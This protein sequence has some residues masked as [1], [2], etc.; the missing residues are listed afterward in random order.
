MTLAE[1]ITILAVDD[2]PVILNTVLSVLRSEYSVVPLSSAKTALKYLETKTADLIL[3]DY[4]MPEM[5]GIKML[6][7]MLADEKLKDIPVIFLTGSMDGEGEAVTLQMGALDYIT[8][9]IRP[10]VLLTRISNQLELL[11]HRKHLE[12]LVA[13]KTRELNHALNLLKLREAVTLNLL[14]RVTEMRDCETGAHIQRTT[15]FVKIIVDELLQN[16]IPGYILTPAEAEDIIDSAKL[17]DLGKIA[18]SDT[19]LLKTDKL[20]T[21]EFEIIKTHPEAG[22][23][24][25]T[26]AIEGISCSAPGEQGELNCDDNFMET[27]RDIAYG[28]HEKWNGKGYPQGLQGDDIPLSARIV[29]IAD[30]Y[31]ALT[32][33][34][35]YKRAFSHEESAEIITGESGQ[36]F[37][38]TL[39]EIFKKYETQFKNVTH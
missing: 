35:P 37:D 28:H 6:E 17:H 31:D 2:D 25:L 33:A 10:Q 27:A 32:S 16:P 26:Q 5:S 38:P 23:K 36:H 9:P 20:T 21:E 22:Q 30:V 11:N 15:D 3:L 7:I 4:Y 18:V 34:R 8:K 12:E 1:K 29:A 13:A 24:L 39:V 19:I 14:A